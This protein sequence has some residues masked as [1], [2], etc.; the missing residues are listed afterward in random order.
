MVGDTMKNSW[1]EFKINKEHQIN[2]IRDFLSF[3]Q[4]SKKKIYKLNIAKA[5]KINDQVCD[6]DTHIKHGDKIDID[7]SIL[8]AKPVLKTKGQVDVVYEDD[9]VI[10]VNKPTRC[11]VYSDGQDHHTL[12]NFVNARYD[13][14]YPILPV[15]R[16][17]YET[18]GLIVFAKHPLMLSYLSKQFE[19]H[20][21]KK[22]YICLVEGH[23]EQRE[24]S[25]NAPIGNDRHSDKMIVHKSGKS[26]HTTYEVI[27]Q[28]DKYSLLKV[29]IT[30]GRKHQIR[31][32]LRSIGYP[33]VS[34]SLYGHMHLSYQ[35]LMLHFYEISFMHPRTHQVL[36]VSKD[37]DF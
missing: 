15:H 33:V 34:D 17:D 23:L 20:L 21:I 2:T 19:D 22:T 37:I 36:T 6:V 4:V 29:G 11:L 18:S 26:A 27:E 8:K 10:I 5:I 28:R 13:H 35:R 31:V 24:G 12:T 1:I 32:H 7:A 14:P 9:D 3:Y 16:I 30:T 25:I